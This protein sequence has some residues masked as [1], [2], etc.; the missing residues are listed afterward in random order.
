MRLHLEFDL[1][2]DFSHLTRNGIG[3]TGGAVGKTVCPVISR[4][5]VVLL[6]RL[7]DRESYFS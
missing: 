3:I 1:L 7:Q 6:D 5:N 2:D 4:G